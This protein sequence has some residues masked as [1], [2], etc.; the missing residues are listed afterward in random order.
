MCFRGANSETP[1]RNSYRA[2]LGELEIELCFRGYR[3]SE[4][5][6]MCVFNCSCNDGSGSLFISSPRTGGTI[7]HAYAWPQDKFGRVEMHMNTYYI[8]A[9]A[10]ARGNTSQIL[11]PCNYIPAII[12]S[13]SPTYR[14]YEPANSAHRYHGPGS[15]IYYLTN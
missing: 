2:L 6:L 8:H 3:C 1:A 9:Y 10:L 5:F 11:P 14:P 4:D 13:R 15:D 12:Q 7:L